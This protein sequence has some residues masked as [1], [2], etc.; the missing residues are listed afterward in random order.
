M[1]AAAP[2]PKANMGQP[3]PR[4][5]GRL[6][7][8]GE[9][10]SEPDTDSIVYDPASKRVF[11]FNGQFDESSAQTLHLFVGRRSKVVSRSHCA[12]PARRSNG[13]QPGHSRADNQNPRRGDGSSRCSEHGKNSG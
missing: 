11:S 5:D 1:S 9:V 4:I 7:V 3:E 2:E 8:T 13:L 6:K 10:K 12:Q